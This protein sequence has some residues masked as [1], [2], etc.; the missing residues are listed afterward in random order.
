M[1]WLCVGVQGEKFTRADLITLQDP[2]SE[3]GSGTGQVTRSIAQFE[4]VKHQLET[5]PSLVA[6][7]GL[8]YNWDVFVCK[9]HFHELRFHFNNLTQI[10]SLSM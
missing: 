7:A 10:W 6:A 3:N 5:A 1:L 2:K 9:F 4:H 8:G